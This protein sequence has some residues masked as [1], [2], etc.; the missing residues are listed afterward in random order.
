MKPHL[1]VINQAYALIVS[2]ESQ[3]SISA[4]SGILEVNPVGNFDIAMYTRNGGGGHNHRLKRN[5]NVHVQF[6][7]YCKIRVTPKKTVT[8]L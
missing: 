3:R 6:Y 5:F 1:P 8:N 7:E 4:K 2:D